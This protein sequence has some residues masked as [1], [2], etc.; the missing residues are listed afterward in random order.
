[1]TPRV[2]FRREAR[3]EVRDA[4]R[5]YQQQVEGLGLEFARAVDAAIAAIAERP[6]AF[7]QV[8]GE[9]RQCVMRRFPYTIFFRSQ[10]GRIVVVAVHH[11]R[12][13]P[14]SWRTRTA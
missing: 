3:A 14:A 9:F 11:Q 7:A 2:V 1:M 13:D 5:W 6:E 12:R 10:P 8:Y 4:R